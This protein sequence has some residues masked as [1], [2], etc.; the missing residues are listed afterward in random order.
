M[1]LQ[2]SIFYTNVTNTGAVLAAA[3]SGNW[4]L[5][6]YSLKSSGASALIDITDAG[7]VVATI[8]L[9]AAANGTTNMFPV[10]VKCSGAIALAGVSTNITNVTLF[11]NKEA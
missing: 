7:A 2:N 5:H 6:G 10:G 8:P 11:F 3:S 9:N 1:S 4:V